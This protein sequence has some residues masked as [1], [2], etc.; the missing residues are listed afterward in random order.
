MIPILLI[1]KPLLLFTIL[2]LATSDQE[3]MQTIRHDGLGGRGKMLI[4]RNGK[5]SNV[6]IWLHGLGDTYESWSEQMLSLD[7]KD[8]KFVLPN[9]GK[10]F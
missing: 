5:Y 3:E 4:P 10:V 7:L 8:T 2:V 1:F 6:V 9:A